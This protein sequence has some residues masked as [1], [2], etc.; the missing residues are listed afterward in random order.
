MNNTRHVDTFV[1]HFTSGQSSGM[2]GLKVIRT[3]AARGLKMRTT[4][5]YCSILTGDSMGVSFKGSSFTL[6]WTSP[7]VRSVSMP[8]RNSIDYLLPI[9]RRYRTVPSSGGCG[10]PF[11]RFFKT[12]YANRSL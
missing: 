10:P 5:T 3:G 6:R 11:V 8:G 12:S 2:N 9:S 7:L 1:R 4:R